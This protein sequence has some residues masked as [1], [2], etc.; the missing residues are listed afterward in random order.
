VPLT[1]I[2]WLFFIPHIS[3]AINTET[4]KLNKLNKYNVLL[5]CWFLLAEKVCG[6]VALDSSG[7]WKALCIIFYRCLLRWSMANGRD[8]HPPAWR[9]TSNILFLTRRQRAFV[10]HPSKSWSDTVLVTTPRRPTAYNRK[11]ADLVDAQAVIILGSTEIYPIH[12]HRRTRAMCTGLGYH[13]VQSSLL[14]VPYPF[15]NTPVLFILRSSGS[16]LIYSS[17]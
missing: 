4:Q 1:H 13:Y 5:K 8:G 15:I 10:N 17:K 6:N 16:S 3:I 12:Q 2:L 7:W 9:I 11:L 14:P